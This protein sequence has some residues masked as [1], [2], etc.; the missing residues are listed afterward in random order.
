M[1]I[2]WTMGGQSLAG[3]T[4]RQVTKKYGSMK[5]LNGIDLA[6]ADGEFLTLVDKFCCLVEGK[7]LPHIYFGNSSIR[8]FTPQQ[9]IP[10]CKCY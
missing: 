3:I 1:H 4:L 8:H 6:I 7:P 10:I 9:K 2:R 5:V